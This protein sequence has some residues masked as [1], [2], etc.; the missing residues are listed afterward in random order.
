MG[1]SFTVPVNIKEEKGRNIRK[2]ELSIKVSQLKYHSPAH[3]RQSLAGNPPKVSSRLVS[4]FLDIFGAK[5]VSS[6]KV[7]RER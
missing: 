5:V 2:G 6:Q 7:R 1:L 4:F 3:S